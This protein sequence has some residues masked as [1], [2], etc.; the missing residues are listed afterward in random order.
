MVRPPRLGGNKKTGLWAT[1]TMF[2]PNPLGLSVVKLED[3]I[4]IDQ[5]PRLQISGMD[6]VDKTPVVDI[7]PYLGYS[8]AIADSVCGVYSTAPQALLQVVFDEKVVATSAEITKE[9]PEFSQLLTETI[10]LQP[11]PAY[12]QE[13]GREYATILYRWNICWRIDDSIATVMAI[14][15]VK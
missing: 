15:E 9:Y 11:K 2:R 10:A 4:Y 8:D 5:Q 7:K 6:I 3:I 13:Q 12:Q 1:R 14:E